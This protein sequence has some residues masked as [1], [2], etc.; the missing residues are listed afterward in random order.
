MFWAPTFGGIARRSTSYWSGHWR[1]SW[2]GLLAILACGGCAPGHEVAEPP[3]APPPSVVAVAPVINLSN[4]DDWDPVRVTDFLTLELQARPEFIV[5]PT[6]RVLAALTVLGRDAIQTPED[7]RALGRELGAD[8]VMVGAVTEYDPYDP[9]RVAWTLQ[10]YLVEPPTRADWPALDPVAASR[11]PTG[12]GV[13]P[14]DVARGE[15]PVLQVQTLADLSRDR[16]RAR[17]RA[18]GKERNGHQSPFGWAVHGKSQQLFLR[19]SCQ[20]AILTMTKEMERY[21]SLG[22]LAEVE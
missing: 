12:T 21:R 19:F 18:Y 16:V 2:L 11:E 1:V 5:V 7:V 3:L 10:M 13:I 9:P 6:A 4:R 17:M 22:T 20:D 8:L 15:A 14:P